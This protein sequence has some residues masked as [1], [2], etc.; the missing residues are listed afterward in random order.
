M[1]ISEVQIRNYQS[2]RKIDLELGAF[3]VIVGASSSGKSAFIRALRALVSNQ[4]GTAFITQGERNMSITAFTDRG[5]VILKR[6]IGTNGNEYIIHPVNGEDKKFTKLSG[7]VPDEVSDFIGIQS[8]DP[9][10]FSSQFDKPFLLDES[11][12]EVARILGALTNSHIVSN[13]AREA[14]RLKL[15]ASGKLSVRK[16]D[17]EQA[18]ERLATLTAW[19][20]HRESVTA[21]ESLL[22]RAQELA[23]ELASL[24]KMK[25]RV[26]TL[27]AKLKRAKALSEITV[28]DLTEAKAV[29]D[30][31]K[32]LKSLQDD[33]DDTSARLKDKKAL[34]KSL[35]EKALQASK[36]HTSLLTELGICP[37]C[38]QETH[39]LEEHAG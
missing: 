25:E 37:T 35:N 8:K 6:S 32:K 31:L 3:T 21:A 23:S 29:H 24:D 18:V 39:N 2:L 26:G 28:P 17:L 5:K 15:S 27:S 1:S 9:L 12:A 36:D 33:L 22:E 14:N 30:E 13:A 16:E 4:R 7:S 20:V 11:P 10:N 38:G 19:E 34:V